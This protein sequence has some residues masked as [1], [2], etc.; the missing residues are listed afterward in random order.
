MWKALTLASASIR[1]T[2]V[3]AS[4]RTTRMLSSAA[5]PHRTASTRVIVAESSIA[6]KSRSGNSAARS[7]MNSPLPA[8]ISISIGA[9]RPN[10]AGGSIVKTSPSGV[11][12]TRSPIARALGLPQIRAAFRSLAM[13][14]ADD[15]GRRPLP[16][17]VGTFQECADAFRERFQV[18][19]VDQGA[20][21]ADGVAKEEALIEDL[22]AAECAARDLP[23]QSI[24]R[25]AL[26]GAGVRGSEVALE[27]G[28]LGRICEVGRGRCRHQG[29]RAVEL[30]YLDHARIQ[31]RE[32][33][34]CGVE[35]R[36][37][38]REHTPLVS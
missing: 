30:D 18:G 28:Q 29:A 21:H 27:V 2:S 33:I 12:S 1:L 15:S 20:G 4:I 3:R 34:A 23:R 19:V 13:S 38:R 35:R 37:R 26:A 31:P 22:A 8:P 36:T 14:E 16:L 10:I 17:S 6:I 11:N 9:R 5:R 32:K 7:M 24:E 25:D